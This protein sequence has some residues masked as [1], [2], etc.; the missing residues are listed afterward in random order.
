MP[1]EE[2][3][4]VFRR[5]LP[6]GADIVIMMDAGYSQEDTSDY[7]NALLVEVSVAP[8][9]DNAFGDDAQVNA[10]RDALDE[11]KS[12]WLPHCVHVADIRGNNKLNIWFYVRKDVDPR[13]QLSEL[14]GK[15]AVRFSFKP[16]PQWANYKRM[17]PSQAEQQ[18]NRNAKQLGELSKHGDN[19]SKPRFV[20]HFFDLA[21]D[22]ACSKVAAVLTKQGFKEVSRLP[23]DNTL[24][25]RMKKKHSI[26]IY[27]INQITT[28]LAN[29]AESTGGLYDGWGCEV[30]R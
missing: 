7:P 13:P 15:F 16:D 2:S 19:F 27:T 17:L 10:V 18:P 12:Q 23:L 4:F 14:F 8:S 1:H 3:W 29:L 22:G 26:E 9:S 28:E 30:T 11:N 24:S 21:T 25:L 5:T 6:Q 20:D